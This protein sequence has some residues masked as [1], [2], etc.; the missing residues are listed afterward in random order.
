[1]TKLIITPID[2]AARGSFAQRKAMLH[3]IADLRRAREANDVAEMVA[4]F[5]AIEGLVRD[6]LETDDGTTID[7]ALAMCSANEFDALFSG[8]INGETIPNASDAS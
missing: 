7:D 1:M 8:L 2:M 4:V 6:H 5:D 3:A